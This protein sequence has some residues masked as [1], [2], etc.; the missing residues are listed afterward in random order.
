MSKEELLTVCHPVTQCHTF[1]LYNYDFDL[2]SHWSSPVLS[3]SNDPP[4]PTANGVLPQK[5]LYLLW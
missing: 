5:T 2:F 1:H 3:P 4:H